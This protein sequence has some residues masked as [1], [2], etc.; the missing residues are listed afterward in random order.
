MNKVLVI[1]GMHRSGTSLTAHW[2]QTCGLPIGNELLPAYTSN[3]RGHFEDVHFMRF[4]RRILK[5]NGLDYLVR[6][7][8]LI[9][10]KENDYAEAK[11]LIE[12]YNHLPQWGWKDPRTCLFLTFWKTLIPDV[13]VLAIFRN[14]GQ[15]IHSLLKRDPPSLPFLAYRNLRRFVL[16]YQRYNQDI[17]HFAEKHPE[18]IRIMNIQVILQESAQVIQQLNQ[19]WGFHLEAHPIEKVF[20]P[21]LLHQSNYPVLSKFCQILYPPI[22]DTYQ[23][24]EAQCL[25]GLSL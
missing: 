9:S 7:H 14:Y 19:Q 8:D 18:A 11:A 6:P 25:S 16:A 10:L 20:E 15:V 2:L 5:N 22:Q 23:Q 24:L 4:Q 1:T 17:L 12:D 21:H 13:K 3:P